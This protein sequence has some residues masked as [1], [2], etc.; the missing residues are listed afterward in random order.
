M[1]KIINLIVFV[2]GIIVL[3]FFF[4]SFIFKMIGLGITWIVNK[5]H[6]SLFSKHR[7][8]IWNINEKMNDLFLFLLKSV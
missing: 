7:V 4:L 8:N 5:T 2:A 3:P 6:K 1:E